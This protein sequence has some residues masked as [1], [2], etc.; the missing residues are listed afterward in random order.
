LRFALLIGAIMILPQ[1]DAQ[2]IDESVAR[3]K[4]LALEHILDQAEA[5]GD[6]KALDDLFDNRLI[7]ID[8]DGTAL[9][10]PAFLSRERSLHPQQVV[11]EVT[12]V[13]IFDDT[14]IVNGTHHS[15]E[16]RN[17][18]LQVRQFSFTDTW[19]QKGSTWVCITAQITPI[20]RL[21]SN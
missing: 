20:L 17:G 14:A 3:T 12:A 10:K 15:K 8:A 18:R 21:A 13:Q 1:I 19:I 9:N 2:S 6:Q 7:Y 16:F 4:L 5:S 11:S